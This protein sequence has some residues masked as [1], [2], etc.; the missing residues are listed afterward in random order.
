[1]HFFLKE[2]VFYWL[3]THATTKQN[4]TKQAN[5]HTAHNVTYTCTH[6]FNRLKKEYFKK[7]RVS[8]KMTHINLN[9]KNSTDRQTH[10]TKQKTK[11]NEHL[12]NRQYTQKNKRQ[13]KK[14]TKKIYHR[15]K[16]V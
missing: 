2:I 16:S 3:D 14:K 6:T 7:N 10:K 1:M 9:H 11:S 8:K 13:L 4:K 5:I 12:N 15:Q